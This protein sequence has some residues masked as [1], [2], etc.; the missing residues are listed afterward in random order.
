MMQKN[1][2]LSNFGCVILLFLIDIG[3]VYKNLLN[4]LVCSLARSKADVKG[5][6]S[7]SA[8][9]SCENLTSLR[10]PKFRAVSNKSVMLILTLAYTDQLLWGTVSWII[11]SDIFIYQHFVMV[12]IQLMF[13]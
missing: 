12:S 10:T 5:K 3:C 9:E 7:T 11:V 2:P 4:C 1:S 8:E 6:W 13:F